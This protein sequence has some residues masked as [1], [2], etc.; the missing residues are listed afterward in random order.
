M[1][2]YQTVSGQS[3]KKWPTSVDE[4]GPDGVFGSP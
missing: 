1:E 2:M 4:K 3:M